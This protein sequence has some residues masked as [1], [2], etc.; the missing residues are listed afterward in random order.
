MKLTNLLVAYAENLGEIDELKHK[1]L[2]DKE[3]SLK[4]AFKRIDENENKKLAAKEIVSFLL[5]NK[6]SSLSVFEIKDKIIAKY[7]A[8]GDE[9]LDEEEFMNVI[10]PLLLEARV[11]DN[12]MANDGPVFKK[13]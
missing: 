6:V 3:F 11:K 10:L 2:K 8:D 4:N 1:L 7:D 13:G 12:H 5:D 9:H